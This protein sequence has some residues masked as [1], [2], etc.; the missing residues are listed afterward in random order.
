MIQFPKPEP[1]VQFSTSS[2][3]NQTAQVTQNGSTHTE[4]LLQ[5]LDFANDL[6][7][8]LARHSA[9]QHYWEQLA[10]DVTERSKAFEDGGYAK[11]YAHARR[12]A[13]LF[14][15]ASNIKETLE[16]LRDCVISLFSSDVS[17]VERESHVKV[18]FRGL[19]QERLGTSVKVDAYLLKQSEVSVLVDINEF[20]TFRQGMLGYLAAGWTYEKIQTTKRELDTQALKVQTYAKVLNGT[21]FTM[22]S[23]K[24]LVAP[25]Y[26]NVDPFGHASTNPGP[27]PA[28]SQPPVSNGTI[29]KTIDE[30]SLM[31]TISQSKKKQ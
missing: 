27:R 18:A 8:S 2:I 31:S 30:S 15:H 19:L 13:R 23:Y 20:E 21:A 14:M 17:E 28:R 16:S 9:Q 12:H 22:K 3:H 24:D 26:G 6:L 29:T 7:G 10:I 4:D 5:T 25:N 11:W 1:S